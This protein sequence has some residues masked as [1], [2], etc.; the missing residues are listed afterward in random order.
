MSRQVDIKALVSH[1][2]RGDGSDRCRICMGDTSEG[3]V[4]LEDTVMMDGD[5]PVTLAELLEVI[6][7]VQVRLDDDLP[8][9]LCSVC[10]VSAL[11]AADFRTQCRRSAL[12]WETTLELLDSIHSQAKASSDGKIVAIVTENSIAFKDLDR[13]DPQE[14]QVKQKVKSSNM[15]G[16]K[17]QCPCCGKRFLYAQLLHQHLKESS[18]NQRA[19]HICAGIM[20]REQLLAHYVDV[21]M[22]IPYSCKKCPAMFHN[23]SQYKLHLS[24]AHAPGAC[25]CGECGRS[26]QS[27]HA[28]YAHLTVHAPKTCPGCDELFRNLKC[29]HYHVKRCCNLDKTRLDTH[30]TKNKVT[31]PVKNKNKNIRVGLRGSADTECI[32]DYCKKKFAGKK[33]VTAHIQIVHMKTTH[34]PCVYC[35]KL[36]AAAHMSTHLKKHESNESFKCGHCGIVLKTKLG[37]IQHVRLHTGERPYTCKFCGESFSASSRR[38]EHIRK[39]HR[40]TEIVLKHACSYCPARFRLPYRLKKHVSSVHGDG[41]EQVM[42]FECSECHENFS[43]CRGLLHHS[44]KHQEVDTAPRVPRARVKVD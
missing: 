3:Q 41:K 23:V 42:P 28:Y 27:E 35:G 25:T 11:Q 2:V 19:C 7:G 26:F 40:E 6:T 38:S 37:Y 31:I 8:V 20:T 29:Y 15:K 36:L 39:C 43:S 17:C 44:R 34:R 22:I 33:F 10:S 12:Q 13:S 5:K 1:I 32:C 24:Q 18:D 30:K 4:H 9:G 21:H 16:L 14:V